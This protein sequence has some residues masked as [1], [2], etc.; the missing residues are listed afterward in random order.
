MNERDIMKETRL[1]DM[2]IEKVNFTTSR[3]LTFTNGC[4]NNIA[5]K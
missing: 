4:P 2:G 3:K 5:T 1:G